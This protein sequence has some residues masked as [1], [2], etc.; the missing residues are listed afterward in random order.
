MFVGSVQVREPQSHEITFQ[1]VSDINELLRQQHRGAGVSG[2]VLRRHTQRAKVAVAWLDD[3]VVGVGS[4]VK[5]H[6]LTHTFG[7]MHNLIIQKNLNVLSIGIRIIKTLLDD[8]R[9]MEFFEAGVWFQDEEML[10]ILDALGFKEKP[11][12]R[13]RL[14]LA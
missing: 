9:G 14:K 7:S 12:S 5:V 6:C 11:R 4:L 1:V 10:K 8:P 13:Y 2:D 3:R